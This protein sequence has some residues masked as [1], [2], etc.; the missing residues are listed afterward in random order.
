MAKEAYAIVFG[1]SKFN[2]FLYGYKFI[3]QTDNEA[4]TKILGTKYGIP[5]MAVRRLQYWSIF[6]SGFNYEVQH[7]GS[8]NN[9]ADYLSRVAT[10]CE[11]KLNSNTAIIEKSFEGNTINYIINSDM[12]TLNWKIVHNETKRVKYYVML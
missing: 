2:E 8:K 12:R 1:I 4:L 3:L 7:I 6:L 9:P 10:N 5:K 11:D